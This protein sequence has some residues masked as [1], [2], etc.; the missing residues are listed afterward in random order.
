MYFLIHCQHDVY[1]QGYETVWEYFLVRAPTFK[2]ACN[3]LK[4]KLYLPQNFEDHTY[5][6]MEV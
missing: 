3:L 4:E 6:V 5:S 1:C 2:L